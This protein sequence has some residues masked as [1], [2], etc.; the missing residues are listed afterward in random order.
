MRRHLAL[1]LPALL[2]VAACGSRSNGSADGAAHPEGSTPT[3]GQG[4][5]GSGG[6]AGSDGTSDARSQA[7]CAAIDLLPPIVEVIDAVTGTPICDPVFV[8]DRPDGGSTA[9]DGTAIPCSQ[10]AQEGCPALADGA[11]APC[12]FSI[13]IFYANDVSVEVSH[14]GYETATVHVSSG[15]GGCVAHVAASQVTV[16]LHA[17]TDGPIDGDGG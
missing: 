12:A 9:G 15:E 5:D 14:S 10:S 4:A 3:D 1:A 16:E 6:A 8:V 17:V 2:A 7:D 13:G 11:A